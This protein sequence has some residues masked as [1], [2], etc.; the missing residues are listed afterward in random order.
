MQQCFPELLEQAIED[1][2]AV[3]DL[4]VLRKLASDMIVA[5]TTEQAHDL[6]E[7]LKKQKGH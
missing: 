6:L 3:S 1:V 4:G 7:A 5:R 2:N